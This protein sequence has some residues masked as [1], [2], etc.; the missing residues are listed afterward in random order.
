MLFL[1]VFQFIGPFFNSV[2]D[3]VRKRV[4]S[5]VRSNT[6]SRL[7]S[8]VTSLS[9]ADLFGHAARQNIDACFVEGTQVLYDDPICTLLMEN[10]NNIVNDLDESMI[11]SNNNNELFSNEIILASV[12]SIA[13]CAWQFKVTRN[14]KRDKKIKIDST[15]LSVNNN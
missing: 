5:T 11:E 9:N 15:D 2:Y 3:S 8:A 6:V 12:I 14:S 13:I 7:P 4:G 1:K 10:V